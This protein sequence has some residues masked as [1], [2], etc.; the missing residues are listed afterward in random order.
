M[1]VTTRIYAFAAAAVAGAGLVGMYALPALRGGDDPFAP[2][3]STA[4]AGGSAAIGGPFALIDENGRSVTD[5][6]VIAGPTLI[7]FGYT[8]CPDICPTDVARNAGAVDILEEMGLDVIPVIISVDPGRDTPE[9]LREWTDAIHP[10]LVGLTGTP[11]Q[12]KSVAAAYRT[13]YRLPEQTDD[14]YYLVDHM[15]YTY[16][17]L[18]GFGFAEFYRS[19][20]SPE[21]MAASAACF[22][23]NAPAT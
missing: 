2:C 13:I 10:Q 19:E 17:M 14:P 23:E 3:R 6:D 8:F 18:P 22:V 12:I 9:V 16:L 4:I 7:Y 20:T 1:P 15:T 5:A 21:E 11:E